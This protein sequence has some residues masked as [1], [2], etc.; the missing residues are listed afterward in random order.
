LEFGVQGL[1]ITSGRAWRPQHGD[2][3]TE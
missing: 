1:E 3:V 2:D